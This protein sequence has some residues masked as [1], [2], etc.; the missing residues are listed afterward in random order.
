M[1]R[2][3]SVGC[4]RIDFPVVL[5]M[6]RIERN[7]REIANVAS[8]F[9][10]HRTVLSVGVVLL[11]WALY[12]GAIVLAVL[13]DAIWLKA[14]AVVIAGTAISML[15]ILGHDA[16]HK[17]LV[18]GRAANAILARILFLPCLHNYTLWVIQHNRLHHQDTNVKGLNSYSP[19]S[20][21]E[22]QRM[23]AWR[24]LVERL[25]RSPIGFGLYYLVER[26]WQD[27][28]FPRA[29]ISSRNRVR[30]LI[31]LAV[32]C[33]WS[34][35]VI[36]S[37]YA[38]TGGGGRFIAALVWGFVAPFLIWNQLMGL[39]AFLQHTH[40]RVP[41]FRSREEARARRTQ[42]QLTV[43]VQYPAWYDLLSHNIMQHQAHH[44]SARIPWC[45][46]KAAQQKLR[47]LLGEGVVQER[48]SLAYVI[49]LTRTCQ[50]YDYDRNRWLDFAG[51]PTFELELLAENS[52]QMAPELQ[53]Q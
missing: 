3:H 7:Q 28:F 31:D 51:R 45:R 2:L 16:A 25:Y 15:F 26:W 19:A 38:V 24:R 18:P 23:P 6:K 32:L 27:K 43:L 42:A 14:T 40:P 21:E 35:L 11:D 37:L 13:A 49:R 48:M 39:T 5:K 9:A 50:L 12:L 17:S 29:T 4:N 22:F 36:F 1:L 30:A 33:A 20:I 10:V 52:G 46:L 53:S 47:R 8:E 41:W 34:A 44:V